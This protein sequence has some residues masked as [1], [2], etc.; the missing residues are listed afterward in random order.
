MRHLT[1]KKRL[2]FY[3][4][5]GWILTLGIVY[6]VF[7]LTLGFMQ[8]Q[9]MYFPDPDTFVPSEWALKEMQPLPVTTA[10]GLHLMSW[11]CPPRDPGKL[12]V[13]FMQGNAGQLGYRNYKIRSWLEAGYG[14]ALVG[15]RGFGNPGTPSEEGLN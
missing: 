1:G 10:D 7:I 3:R 2:I 8:R 9:L 11:Y 5:P 6:G 14:A 12:T 4:L 15:Y 13:V